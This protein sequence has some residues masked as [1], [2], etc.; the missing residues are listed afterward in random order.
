[1]N[2]R[3]YKLLHE[4]NA[5]AR[6]VSRRFLFNWFQ[7]LGF[8]ITGDHFYELIPNT[9]HIAQTYSDAPRQL[10]GINWRLKESEAEALRLVRAFGAEYPSAMAK[11]NF[12]DPNPY[13]CGVDAL[14]LYLV[15]RDLKPKKMVEV[16]Q[17]FSTRIALTAL[18]RNAS[19]T[20]VECEFV[21]I[22]PYARFSGEQ[23]PTS[24]KFKLVREEFQKLPIEPLL[25]NC[26]FLFID[27]SHVYK[28]GSDVEFEFTRVY[29]SLR[30]GTLLHVHDIYSPYNYPLEWIVQQKRFW[31]EQYVFEALLM[32]NNAFEVHLPNQLLIR[33]S[34]TFVRDVRALPLYPSFRIEGSSFYMMRR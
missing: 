34:E 25:E 9:R 22:D 23:L 14:M 12:T 28:F 7:R 18:E 6:Y 8:H 2:E 31:N 29:P 1:M 26:D 19:D 17:G 11:I 33:Q 32:F 30:P 10:G 24:V 15:L 4:K 13:F 5:L 3:I 16:G 27:S 21:S 20:G